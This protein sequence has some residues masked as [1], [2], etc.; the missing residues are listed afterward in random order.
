MALGDRCPHPRQAVKDLVGEALK[1]QALQPTFTGGG[2]RK[3]TLM[4]ASMV[5]HV[6]FMAINKRY[7]TTKVVFPWKFNIEVCFGAWFEC[8][9]A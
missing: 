6:E 2:E 7:C 8:S 3:Q 5:V 1:S 4:S 9:S